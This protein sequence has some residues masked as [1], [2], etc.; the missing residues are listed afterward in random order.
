MTSTDEH[1]KK[2]RE[3]LDEIE[4]AIDEGI[5]KKPVTIGFNCSAC[6]VQLLELL[7]HLNNKISAGHII[8]HDWFKKPKEGQKIEPLAERKIPVQ[9]DEKKEIYPLIYEIEDNR[10]N[11]LYG[12][13]DIKKIELVLDSFNKLKSIILPKLKEKGVEI[14]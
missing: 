10:E 11:L 14:E 1:L 6:S 9:F 2:I 7:L 12:K 13:T 3:H 4:N 5:E 8:K